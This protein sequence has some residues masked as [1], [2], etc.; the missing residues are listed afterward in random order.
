MS[1]SVANFE[2]LFQKR[3]QPIKGFDGNGVGLRSGQVQIIFAVEARSDPQQVDFRQSRSQSPAG[4]SAH[5]KQVGLD[6][7]LVVG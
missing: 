2:L 1:E 5:A 7:H 3:I 6:E 4:D